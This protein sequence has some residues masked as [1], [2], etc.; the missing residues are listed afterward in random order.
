MKSKK[1]Y[2]VAVDIGGTKTNIGFFYNTKLEN[3]IN[4]PT[5][6]FGPDNIE[7]I[8]G[9]LIKSKKHISVIGL[10]LTGLINNGLW[11]P[12]NKKT[13]GN[14]KNYPIIK[15]LSSFFNVPVYALGDTQAA[16]LGE[17]Y[18]GAG[19]KFHNFF[20]I[21]IST[22]IGG[23]LIQNRN[24]FDSK[25]SDVGAI[26]H[27]VIKFNGLPC[28]CGRRGCLEVYASGNGLIKLNK[29]KK[30]ANTKDLLTKF[31]NNAQ[32]KKIVDNAVKMI[33]ES[34]TNVNAMLR[35]DNFIM[36]GSVGLNSYF[37]K[38]IKDQLKGMQSPL[39]LKRAKLQSKAEL[40]GCYAYID[41]RLF[42]KK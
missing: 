11:N 2:I 13:L 17:L 15:N 34:L 21:T 31:K 30:C 38:K 42:L 18:F 9:I 6:K 39:M 25:I 4:F 12:I 29:I 1:K 26:G 10:S 16:S 27:N 23:S 7:T 5:N 37:Y 40:Y 24:L 19:K 22:G 14:F 41:K 32:T 35:I 20:Y 3:I 36:G 33:V 8:K 28:G